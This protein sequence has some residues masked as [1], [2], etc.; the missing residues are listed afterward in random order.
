MDAIAGQPSWCPVVS[1][2]R[3]VGT[4]AS[5]TSASTQLSEDPVH[6]NCSFV[7][8]RLC[9][10]LGLRIRLFELMSHSGVLVSHPSD[11]S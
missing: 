9:V 10:C 6:L 4:G 7:L 11:P 1:L 5:K 8:A 2:N 3:V